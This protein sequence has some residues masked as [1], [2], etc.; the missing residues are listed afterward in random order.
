MNSSFPAGFTIL[1]GKKSSR[2]KRNLKILIRLRK[3]KVGTIGI[4][5]K[6]WNEKMKKKSWKRVNSFRK[7]YFSLWRW[8]LRV[9][10]SFLTSR[11]WN[12]SFFHFR[13]LTFS[14]NFFII[15]AYLI[16]TQSIFDEP[17]VIINSA[18]WKCIQ[19]SSLVT[20][21]KTQSLK[22]IDDR[23]NDKTK[24]IEFANYYLKTWADENTSFRLVLRIPQ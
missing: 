19:K 15:N 23:W 10:H 12:S 7:K 6:K 9:T 17:L 5:K 11:Y 1:T 2:I 14:S 13:I 20:I 3:W 24:N 4:K 8:M 21:W 22:F 16:S 18:W